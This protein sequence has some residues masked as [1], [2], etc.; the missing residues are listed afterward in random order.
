MN[1]AAEALIGLVGGADMEYEVRGG[2]CAMCV[3]VGGRRGGANYI[4]HL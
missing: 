1:E 3:H 2:V 4:L